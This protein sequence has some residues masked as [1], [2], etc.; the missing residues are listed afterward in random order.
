MKSLCSNRII[1]RLAHFAS[2]TGKGPTP[3]EE[4]GEMF[5]SVLK[6]VTGGGARQGALDLTTVDPTTSVKSPE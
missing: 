2:S 3:E 5:G 1:Q 6:E 4:E